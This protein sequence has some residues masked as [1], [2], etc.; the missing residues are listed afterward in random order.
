MKAD[1]LAVQQRP[2]HR[3]GCH[4]CWIPRAPTLGSARGSSRNKLETAYPQQ[5][6]KHFVSLLLQHLTQKGCRD[7]LNLLEGDPANSSGARVVTTQAKTKRAAS[8][9]V[10]PGFCRRTRWT[11]LSQLRSTLQTTQWLGLDKIPGFKAPGSPALRVTPLL[12]SAT[13][14]LV[15]VPWNPQ[16]FAAKA[17]LVGYPRHLCLGVPPA[18]RKVILACSK[19]PAAKVIETRAA[20]SRRWLQRAQE[21]NHQ[22][23]K[24]VE[25]SSQFLEE[26]WLKSLDEVSKGCSEGPF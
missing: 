24:E 14:V 13:D 23:I 6:C 11:V 10:I 20:Q 16:E 1:S 18:L 12:S 22:V 3:P 25:D 15:E 19:Q 8:F 26:L 9:Q 21:T 7:G 17:R 5:F 4:V 2:H